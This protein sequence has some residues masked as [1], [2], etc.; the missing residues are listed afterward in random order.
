M[1]ALL[2][3]GFI[4]VLQAQSK[5]RV[6][7]YYA[8]WMQG[9][10]NNG[11]LP[12][13][14]VEYNSLDYVIHF[15][16][17]PNGDGTLD[18]LSNSILSTNSDALIAAAH[19]AGKKVII[20][21]GGWG[22]DDALRS[23]TS[24]LNVIFFV[25]NLVNFMVNRG[26]DGID[27]DWEVLEE[28]DS[29]Q[30]VNFIKRLRTVLDL[31]HPGFIIT[32]ATQWQPQI[33]A[34]VQ[35][36]V[37]QINIMTYD[38][39][40]AWP[41]WV[42]WH[43]SPVYSGGNI[44]PSTGMPVPSIDYMVN[45]FT[46]S[47][48]S[49]SKISI[50]IDYY[51]YVWKGGNGTT[52]GGV[53]EPMQ[54]WTNPPE[55]SPNIPYYEIMDNYFRPEYYR[56]DS[57]AEASYLQIDSSCDDEDE[58]I[59]YDD[60]RT[61]EAKVEYAKKNGLAGVFIWELGGDVTDNGQQPLFDAVNKAASGTISIPSV[62]VLSSPSENS[63]GKDLP[64][65]FSWFPEEMAENYNLQVSSNSGFTSIIFDT[66]VENSTSVIVNNLPPVQK[67]F[68]RVNASN[69]A[70]AG[71]YTSPLS[72]TTSGPPIN[73]PA[74]ISPLDKASLL[75][76]NL[77]LNWSSSNNAG[78]YRLQIAASYDFCDLV[79]DTTI[80]GDTTFTVNNLNNNENYFWHVKAI[81]KNNSFASSVFSGERSFTTIISLPNV[82][83][84][85]SPS[86]GENSVQIDPTLKW[87]NANYASFFRA[88]IA[89]NDNFS[90]LTLDTNNITQTFLNLYN[91]KINTTYYWRIKSYN[92]AGQSS[93]S[94]ASKFTTEDSLEISRGPYQNS[95]EL[96]Q[97]YPDP[98][99][100]STVIQ[101]KLPQKSN[102]LLFISDIMGR[103]VKILTSGI[104][105]EGAYKF[106]FD[107]GNLSSGIY[108]YTFK[109]IPIGNYNGRSIVF[110][111]KMVL[112]K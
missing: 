23:A 100:N 7:G 99:N 69:S 106:S 53:T 39:S 9:W 13:S 65:N 27:I 93:W 72:F 30:Y 14:K 50:G 86:D 18:Y 33:I 31:I 77:K 47:G 8:G 41:G 73:S 17:E 54:T 60:E 49:K 61:C 48:V 46:S 109:A 108:F 6:T 24:F 19:A 2:S 103:Q 102:V 5:I 20:C 59:S 84:L 70:G 4:Y 44:F 12:S 29:V 78:S 56:W 67:L 55:V 38:L 98:F 96:E 82:P 92:G 97:N 79:L 51:G 21:A 110:T 11:R 64:V 16:I 91:L 68:W 94:A 35:N 22:S 1:L 37:N 85:L 57:G 42:T 26:Y 10:Y 104:L 111:K 66:T 36:Y 107:S 63:H 80:T 62:P 89:V 25:P 71:N 74:L 28:S 52:T 43:N 34:A 81:P 58:F 87:A 32:V 83:S 105:D 3:S 15:A 40:G 75:A 112:L 90:N 88:Q 101:F 45:E 95:F 76:I